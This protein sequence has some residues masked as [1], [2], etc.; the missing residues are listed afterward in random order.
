MMITLD[1]RNVKKK[2][3]IF[4]DF[5]KSNGKILIIFCLLGALVS[6]AVS[7][8]F[9]EK[10]Y[11]AT[12]EVVV[13]EETTANKLGENINLAWLQT[14]EDILKSD[15]LLNNV[16]ED[17]NLDY[18]VSE[19]RENIEVS[20]KGNSLMFSVQ[21]QAD[22]PKDA[23]ELA[24]GILTQFTGKITEVENVHQVMV[25]DEV[26]THTESIYPSIPLNTILG[27]MIGIAVGLLVIFL[28]N[29][30]L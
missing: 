7:I 9:I 16:L 15:N 23:F 8:F 28:R 18:L 1:L 21:V 5:L 13:D 30:K 19:L 27:G 4:I 17:K 10:K 20:T 26:K 22:T 14:Y 3:Q 11:E 24:N 6:G 2:F 12:F 25:I 29:I